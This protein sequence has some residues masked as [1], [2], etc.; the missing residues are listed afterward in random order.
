MKLID[1]YP[2]K[3]VYRPGEA[4]SLVV[5]IEAVNPVEG[6]LN[7]SLYHMEKVLETIRIPIHPK[8]GS[9]CIPV[10]LELVSN[11]PR[12]YGLEAVLLDRGG[13]VAG[14]A[15][16]AF[17]VQRSWTDYPR[18][19]F[20]TRFGPDPGE[21]EAVEWL[22][23]FHING[24]QFYDW[25]YRHDQLLAPSERYND[26]LGRQLSLARVRRLI[27]DAHTH[28][29]AAMAYLA[30]YA[31]SLSFAGAH[32]DWRLQTEKGE[33]LDFEGFLGLMDPTPGGPWSEHL[34]AECGR[35]LAALPF[36]GLHVDQYGEPRVGF[37]AR[38]EPVDLPTAFGGFIA[39]LKDR[40][41]AAP[42]TFNAVKNWPIEALAGAPLDFVYVEL[43]PD[44]PGYPEV[45]KIVHGARRLSGGKPVVVAQYIPAA[46]TANLR[47]SQALVFALGGSRIELGEERR[48]LSDP[49]FPK[50]EAIPQDLER[51]LR[52]IYDFVVRYG[53][54]IGPGAE[55][56]EG[57]GVSTP[58]GVECIHR[59]FGKW[60]ALHL[61]NFTGKSNARWCEA[62]RPPR[63][64]RDVQLSFPGLDPVLGVWWATPDRPGISLEPLKWHE[65][66]ERIHVIVPSLEY[67]SM[68]VVDTR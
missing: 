8:T 41:P 65:E 53:E 66:G 63:R 14:T 59:R 19:G 4:I 30:V 44:T 49:Y 3:G 38:G 51:I 67:W 54:L 7:L 37:N 31:A 28:G 42:V 18:Y 26:P 27:E 23:R 20:L 22:V 17:D 25:Q 15:S 68:I 36:D 61:L 39:A 32:P 5:V 56:V 55:M 34:L 60:S 62:H 21:D 12:G 58:E 33:P 13:R 48:L 45:F 2:C 9:Q 57:S 6:E 64:L 40:F 29:M 47:L 52:Q 24:L 1:L 35:T 43:W 16:T 10:T 46:H 50:H 11:I